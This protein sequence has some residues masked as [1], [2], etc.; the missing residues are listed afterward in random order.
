MNFIINK[1]EYLSA[2]VA[3]N[4]IINRT[5]TDHIFYNALRGH[6]LKR[7]F[8]PIQSANKLANGISPWNSFDIAKKDAQW[9]IRD[10][11]AMWPQDT[12]ERKARRAAEEKERIDSLGK[13]YGVIFTTDLITTLRE[14]FK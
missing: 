7:G 8:S 12:P 6:D 10:T 9:Q 4:K 13:K 11:N 14:L 5:A 3:W 1:E 2:I